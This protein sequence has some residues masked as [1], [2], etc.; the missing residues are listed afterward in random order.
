VRAIGGEKNDARV[1]GAPERHTSAS[2]WNQTV[3][4]SASH[5]SSSHPASPISYLCMAALAFLPSPMARIAVAAPRTMSP[6]ANTPGMLVRQS[7]SMTML[8]HLFVSSPAAVG[9]LDPSDSPASTPS[10]LHNVHKKKWRSA[11]SALRHFVFSPVLAYP[12]LQRLQQASE[13]A[14]GQRHHKPALSP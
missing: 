11:T 10:S 6:P 9:Y 5:T 12:K 14:S 3:A 2:V 7:S 4:A 8:P 13:R 1:R